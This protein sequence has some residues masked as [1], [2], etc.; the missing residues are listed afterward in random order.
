MITVSELQ[1]RRK[2]ATEKYLDE[3][4]KKIEEV[5]QCGICV[6]TPGVPENVDVSVAIR[7]LTDAGYRVEH[8]KGYHARRGEW[9]ILKIYWD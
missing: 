2:N 7:V 1:S 5:D 8:D 6:W 4:S 9:N 3:I